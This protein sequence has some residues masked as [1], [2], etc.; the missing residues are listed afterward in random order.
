VSFFSASK[1]DRDVKSKSEPARPVPAEA[2]RLTVKAQDNVS[3][4]ASG[5]QVTGNIVCTGQLQIHGRVVGDIHAAHLTI[6]EGARIEGKIVAPETVIQGTF[7]GSIHG[8]VVKLQK[9]ASVEGEIFNR[10][11]AIEQEARFEGVARRLDQPVA[12]PTN[13]RLGAASAA[14]GSNGAK[15]PLEPEQTQSAGVVPA[16]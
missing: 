5:M 1:N 10:S 15:A 7:N 3:V 6:C 11:L 8:N 16:A 4:L 12:A 2:M 9:T 13:E 14:G